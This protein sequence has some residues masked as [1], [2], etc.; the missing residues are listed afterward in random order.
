M[1]SRSIGIWAA[2]KH[3]GFSFSEHRG[4]GFSCAEIWLDA[5]TG[6]SLALNWRELRRPDWRSVIAGDLRILRREANA[7]RQRRRNAAV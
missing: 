3:R 7:E 6:Y 2:S 5:A 4:G 1:S